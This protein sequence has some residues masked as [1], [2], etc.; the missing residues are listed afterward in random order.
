MVGAVHPS[1]F[2]YILPIYSL[3]LLFPTSPRLPWV[4]ALSL[5]DDLL[6][7]SFFLK[8][9]W[10]WRFRELESKRGDTDISCG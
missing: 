8:S 1:V 2:S 9:K 7:N 6:N 4:A 5:Y 10:H 3:V